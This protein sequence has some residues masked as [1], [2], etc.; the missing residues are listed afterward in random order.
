MGKRGFP[1]KPA[2]LKLVDGSRTD[3]INFDEPIVSDEPPIAPDDMS[4]EALAIWD[5]TVG[6]LTAMK[7]AKA[8]DRHVLRCYCEAVVNH[9]KASQ[10]LAKS[11]ILIKGIMGGLVRNPALTVQYANATIVRHFAQEFGLTPSARSSIVVGGKKANADEQ[12]H[13]PFA[14]TG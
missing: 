5:E 14:E 7:I 3:R 6:H 12:L 10:I 4:P 9:Q 13:N 2:A 1:A 8:P 11:P